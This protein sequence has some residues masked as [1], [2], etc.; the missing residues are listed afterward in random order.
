[1]QTRR[2]TISILLVLFILAGSAAAMAAFIIP[3]AQDLLA[4]A[5][6]RAHT[7]TDGHAIA[8]FEIDTPQQS[9]SGTMEV[10][11]RLDAGP[12]GEPAFRVEVLEA[13]EAEMVGITAVSD[14]VTFWLYNPAEN[15]VLTGTVDE[16]KARAAERAGDFEGGHDFQRDF[17]NE[18]NDEM[19]EMPQT[20]EEAV[21]K[22]LEYFTANRETT[23][24]VG[25]NRAYVVRLV[26]IPEQMPD[27]VR[28]AGGY[29]NV[30]IRAEDSALL[31]AE[32]VQ[33]VPGYAKAV[34]TTLEINQGVDDALFTFEIPAGAEVVNVADLE[35][36]AFDET[37]APDFEPLAATN[38]PAGAEAGETAVVRGAVVQRYTLADGDFFIAQ[39][40]AR[41]AANL[42]GGDA[43][44]PVTVR[45]VEGSLFS[46]EDGRRILLTWTEGEIT[47][48]IGGSLTAEQALAAAESLQ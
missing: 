33:G 17:E 27:E 35:M 39:G 5:I 2:R 37:A 29:L 28:A 26:P 45:G 10:W 15:K 7:V 34:A 42:F 19:P 6:E 41:A 18:M 47:Y 43:G 4:Q 46:E 3:S 14:G 23:V 48:W 32:Y 11:G 22:L 16:L 40:P 1:M 25:G 24:D 8:E 44:E 12:N 9:G 30:W 13:S 20:P 38:L 31:G 21:A 36:P